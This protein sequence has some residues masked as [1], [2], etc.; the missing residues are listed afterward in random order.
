MS[1]AA[2]GA[3]CFSRFMLRGHSGPLTAMVI[4]PDGRTNYTASTDGTTRK[5]D[6]PFADGGAIV[7]L[8]EIQDDLVRG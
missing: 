3:G 5:V 1:P 4:A 8:A 2:I 6:N 7:R